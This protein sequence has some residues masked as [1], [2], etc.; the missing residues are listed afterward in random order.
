MWIVYN[1]KSGE[2]ATA[3]DDEPDGPL[4]RNIRDLPDDFDWDVV[5]IHN[6]PIQVPT[7]LCRFINGGLIILKPESIKLSVV[8]ANGDIIVK[9]GSTV[10]LQADFFNGFS[11]PTNASGTLYWS[12]DRGFIRPKKVK[13]TNK[14]YARASLLV[15]NENIE[16]SIRCSLVGF[17]PGT[18]LLSVE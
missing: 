11:K 16:I 12:H 10:T 8:G 18:L 1:K 17:E 15:P 7:G 14:K 2:I 3:I 4:L 6:Y 9:P 5:Y 13:I